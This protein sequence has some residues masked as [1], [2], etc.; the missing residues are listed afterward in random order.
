MDTLGRT[1][2][3]KQLGVDYELIY[4]YRNHR[5]R[6]IEK[7]SGLNWDKSARKSASDEEKHAANIVR[8]AR[9]HDYEELFKNTPSE[10]RP[11]P[12][13]YEMG[14]QFLTNIPVIEVSKI[15]EM[16]RRM[17][18]GALLH[19]HFNQQLPVKDLLNKCKDMVT[20]FIRST[21]ALLKERNW[22]VIEIQ[23]GI[24]RPPTQGNIFSHSYDECPK[25]NNFGPWMSWGDFREGFPG[26]ESAAE[27][28]IEKKLE[29][30]AREVY[31]EDQNI[32]GIWARFNEATRCFK[33]FS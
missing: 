25:E 6:L 8:S 24:C 7:D 12:G 30:N 2:P 20:M 10:K 5:T 31:S 26:G 33:D 4:R 11:A 28:W 29:F 14:G 9:K 16:A 13:T 15:Y 22:D 32:N 17:P 19:L 18:K 23:F 1:E 21:E 27:K 3:P